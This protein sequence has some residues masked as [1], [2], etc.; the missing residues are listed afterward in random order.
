MKLLMQQ[1]TFFGIQRFTRQK[2]SLF[3]TPSE[4]ITTHR[5]S[6]QKIPPPLRI[7]LCE[8]RHYILLNFAK[9][10]LM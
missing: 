5:T 8:T 4:R 2:I 6:L 9:I 1:V 7:L 10:G 3:Q